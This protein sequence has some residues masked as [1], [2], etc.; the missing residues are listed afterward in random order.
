MAKAMKRMGEASRVH[1]DGASTKES[2]EQQRKQ[3]ILNMLMGGKKGNVKK[4]FRAWE[5]GTAMSKKERRVRDRRGA[6]M[7]SCEH[8]KTPDDPHC[9][10]CYADERL[11]PSTF[12]LPFD[13]VFKTIMSGAFQAGKAA[14]AAA[15][16][17]SLSNMS[18][19][20]ARRASTMDSPFKRRQSVMKLKEEAE[21]QAARTATQ[22]SSDSDEDPR[23]KA[24][25]K[26]AG[27]AAKSADPEPWLSGE[28]LEQ[29][30]H[31]K[32]GRKL[33]LDPETMRISFYPGPVD[34]GS[35]MPGE[36]PTPSSPSQAVGWAADL[37][38]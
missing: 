18:T 24:E 19:R 30:Q 27:P 13:A 29:V 17:K 16:P 33:F 12:E 32:N 1:L 22:E 23:F 5:V 6:W 25:K 21:A 15:R 9:R 34:P 14:A 8:V 26:K 4:F 37:L 35:K 11:T 36:M 7:A 28:G 2:E 38:E 3:Q 31:Y 10:N 20:M